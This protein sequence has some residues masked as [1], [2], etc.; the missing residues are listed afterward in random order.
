M[1]PP[2]IFNYFKPC[3]GGVLSTQQGT[4]SDSA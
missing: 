2:L 1:T 4:L 3:G